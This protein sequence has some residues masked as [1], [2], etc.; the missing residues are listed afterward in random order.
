MAP[1]E[2]AVKSWA[3]LQ[4]LWRRTRQSA[5]FFGVFAT[6]VRVGAALFLLPF[7]LTILPAP[8]MA[9]WWVFGSLGGFA[10]L[11]DFGFGSAITRVYSYLWAGA[12]DFDAEGLRPPSRSREPNLP[13]VRQLH[14]T[15][16]YFYLR[17]ALAA[18]L[19]LA[20][21]WTCVLLKPMAAVA[22]PRLI[23]VAWAGYVLSIGYNLAAYRW[24]LA[25]Q[26]L[27]RMREMQIATICSGLTNILTT[28][29]LLVGGCGF[30]SLVAGSFL[31]GIILRE[32]CRRVYHSAVPRPDV[33]VVKAD[34]GMLKRL[35]PNAWKLGLISLGSFCISNGN[36]LIC[37]HFLSS[38]VTADFGLTVQIGIF[39]L[40]FATLWLSVK[41]PELAMLRS[42]G[43]LHEMSVLF[44]RR[45]A[46]SMATFLALAVFVAV[47]GNWL[48]AW[49]GTQTRLL[50]APALLFYFGYLAQQIFYAQFGGLALTENVVPFYKVAICT[51]LGMLALSLMLTPAFGLWGMLLAP[52]LAESACNSWY[53][54]RR[55]FRGQPLTARQLLKAALAGHL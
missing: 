33:P 5:V 40:N 47:A 8:E 32:F 46:F 37:S 30:L 51:G 53:T 6:V 55:G 15:V 48:L 2:A 1:G 13:R 49:K 4:R 23:W 43:R 39:S 54:L 22:Q 38:K 24:V 19:L 21:G 28:A 45:L 52:L 44:A 14:V 18:T 20:A 17:L 41:W 7:V 34:L 9:V 50:P 31:S 25:C 27:G 29:A 42:Q 26:G 11:A 36:V 10:N 12:E 3:D 16:G 35:W